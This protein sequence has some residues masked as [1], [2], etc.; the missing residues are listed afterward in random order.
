MREAAVD[1]DFS[2]S[3]TVLSQLVS[4]LSFLKVDINGLFRSQGVN[5]VILKSPDGRIPLETYIG[6][7]G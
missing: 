4:Y 3:V 6:H 2:V 5:P 7:R 1:S